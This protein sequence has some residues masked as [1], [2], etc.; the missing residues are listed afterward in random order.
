MFGAKFEMSGIEK[1]LLNNLRISVQILGKSSW[2]PMLSY[3]AGL[4]AQSVHPPREPFPYPW[5]EIGPGY[6]YGP[7]F[8]HW[9]VVHQ[10]LDVQNVYLTHAKRQL[11]NLFAVQDADGFLPGVVWM[12][13]AEPR[14]GDETTHPPVWPFALESCVE[15]SDDPTLLSTGFDALTRQIE[16]FEANRRA[17]PGGFYYRDILTRNWESGVDE[18]VRFD[19]VQQGPFACVDATAH[20]YGLYAHGAVWA[21][22][23]GRP[24]DPFRER[25]DALKTFMQTRLYAEDDGFFYDVWAADDPGQRRAALEGMWPVV[26][27]AATREQAERVIDEHLLNPDRFFTAHP[28]STVGINDSHFELRMWRGPTWNS[29][30]Y[31]AARGCMAYDRPDAARQLLERALDAS[32]AQFK[33]THTIWEFYHPRGG[34]PEILARK[35]H[36][37]YNQPC[38]DYLGHNPL[39]AM[40]RLWEQAGEAL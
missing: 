17:E 23:L 33:R 38:K 30:T 18:G 25:A 14:W 37:D 15:Q 36:T 24:A 13:E 27:G 28:V 34:E 4:H 26:V 20:V 29:M 39:F 3:V 31:W 1:T 7:A 35:P 6:C 19:D 9:D 40:T 5:E 22:R 11:L 10:I 16:W 12:R 21:E 32:A 8:G 2:R